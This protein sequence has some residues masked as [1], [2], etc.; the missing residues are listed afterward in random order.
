MSSKSHEATHTEDAAI[1]VPDST[2]QGESGKLKMIIQLVKKCFG[3]KDIATMRI[4][5]PAS[6]LEPIPNLEYWHYL[7]R[8]D[9][10]A[11]INDSNDPFER[12]LAVIRFAFTKDLRHVHGRVI[13]P[14]NSVLGEHFRAHWDVVPASLQE[15]HD[16]DRV[17]VRS[18]QSSDLSAGSSSTS[19][20]PSS[21]KQTSSTP[22]TSFTTSSQDT[23]TRVVYLTEQISHHPPVSAFYASCPSKHIEMKGIDQIV[24]KVTGSATVRISPGQFTKGI[25]ISLNGGPGAGESYHISHITAHVNGIL[26]GSFY[27][28]LS[29]SMIITCKRD[30]HSSY[31]TIVEYKEESWLGRAH[32]LIEGVIHVVYDSDDSNQIAQWTKVRQ[33]PHNRVAAVLD[34][35]WRGKVRWKRVGILSYPQ[36]TSTAASSPNPSHAQLPTPI[37]PAASVSKA[38]V[39]RSSDEEWQPL[40]DLD[41]LQVL[42]KEVRPVD[43]QL[44][45][46][47]RK[48]WKTVTDK[49][50][51]KEYSDATREKHVIEQRQRDEA[52]ERKRKGVEFVSRYFENDTD[53]GFADLTAEGKKAIEEELAETSGSCIEG[54][55]QGVQLGP[56]SPTS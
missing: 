36:T 45:Q 33:V 34:G 24:A 39:L 53:R 43:K 4:S 16:A 55:D 41:S 7:D 47:S 18:G 52:A 1:S 20:L 56:A 13:K 2:D 30:A 22:A 5:L 48:L 3:V 51:N 14:Y 46:E 11:A 27:V 10:F 31:R 44:P 9:F 49:L 19:N 42:E 54:I 8:A 12:M 26:R 28:T 17:S 21:T 25:F 40:I 29:D 50:I 38:D 32:Y 37:L 15:E 23:R 35:C 6:L